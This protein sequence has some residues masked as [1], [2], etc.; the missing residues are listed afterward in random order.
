[1]TRVVLAQ[2]EFTVAI[3]G[4]R[5]ILSALQYNV[6]FLHSKGKMHE[7]TTA[8]SGL[9]IVGHYSIYTGHRG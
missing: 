1:M 8:D 3:C 6:I 4:S 7:I 9:Y 5:K 2:I